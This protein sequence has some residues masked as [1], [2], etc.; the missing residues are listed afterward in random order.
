MTR[1]EKIEKAIE[2]FNDG[3]LEKLPRRNY[4]DLV[5]E[6]GRYKVINPMKYKEEI[7]KNMRKYVEG[8]IKPSWFEQVERLFFGDQ[9]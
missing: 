4:Y 2:L 9:Q 5:L 1:Q 3:T 6:V 8:K 7:P